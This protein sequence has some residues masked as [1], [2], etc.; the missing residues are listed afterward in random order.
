ML[1]WTLTRADVARILI[2]A[3]YPVEA[4]EFLPEP[5]Q[6][7][8]DNDRATLNM[9][10]RHYLALHA[11]EKKGD[12]LEQAWNVIQ[13]VLADGEVEDEDKEEALKRAVDIAPKIRAELGQAWLDESFSERPEPKA[14]RC[15]GRPPTWPTASA[16]AC[17]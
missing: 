15:R 3:G 10:S 7:T 9:L 5:D 6:A 2:E 17:G 8:A 1:G 4:G 14:S 11:E 16:A 12:H 13:A